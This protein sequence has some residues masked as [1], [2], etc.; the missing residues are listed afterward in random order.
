PQTEQ[1]N[2]DLYLDLLHASEEGLQYGDD[3]MPFRNV[4]AANKWLRI[5]QREGIQQGAPETLAS[6]PHSTVADYEDVLARLST[7]PKSFDQEIALLQEGLKRGYTQPKITL[8]DVPQQIADLAPDDPLKSPLLDP[9]TD[10]P[11]A[12]PEAD[13]ARL[14]QRAREIYT[15]SLAPAIRRFHKFIA[16]AYLPSCR[17]SIASTAIPNAAAA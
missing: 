11:A 8:R 13:R 12:I 16:D 17:D 4:I 5:N 10:F 2:Y 6:A 7:L 3:P 1:L 9:F 15:S 14:I